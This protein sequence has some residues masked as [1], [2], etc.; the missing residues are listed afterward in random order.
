MIAMAEKGKRFTQK[1]TKIERLFDF[2]RKA[3]LHK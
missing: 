3:F 1:E 2:F